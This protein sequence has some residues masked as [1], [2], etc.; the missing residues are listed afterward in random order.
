ML[1]FPTT[2]VGIIVVI[3][4]VVLSPFVPFLADLFIVLLCLLGLV[5]DLGRLIARRVDRL[6]PSSIF[7]LWLLLILS[8][9]LL[10]SLLGLILVML[11][12]SHVSFL[13][14]G[15]PIA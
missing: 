10:L 12:L 14:L 1:R 15:P 4:V 3:V 11:S 5:I 8:R 7:T 9:A 13:V 2:I 6:G